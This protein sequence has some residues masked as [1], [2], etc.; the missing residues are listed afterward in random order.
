MKTYKLDNW[1]KALTN[2]GLL[3]YAETMEVMLFHHSHDSYRVPTLN[4]KFLCFDIITTIDQIDGLILD[5]GNLSPLIDEFMSSYKKDSVIQ[6]LYGKEIDKL[7]ETKDEH[8]VYR[9]QFKDIC[10]D[11]NSEKARASLRKTV[12]FLIDDLSNGDKYYKNILSQLKYYVVEDLSQDVQEQMYP[13]IQS[14]LSELMNRGYTLE[15]LY[16]TVI[17]SFFNEYEIKDIDAAFNSFI[18][19][20]S[21]DEK[22]YAVYFPVDNS[23]KDDLSDCFGLSIAEN[24]FEMFNNQ[25]RYVGKISIEAMDPQSAREEVSSIIDLF[26]SIIEYDKHSGKS[27]SIK[28]TDIVDIESK[29]CFYY[30][31]SFPP[32]LRGNRNKENTFSKDICPHHVKNLFNAISLHANAIKSNDIS[33]Q[34]LNLWTAIEVLVPTERKGLYSRIIQITNVLTTVLSITHFR[35]LLLQ[36]SDDIS[37]VCPQYDTYVSEIEG[38]SIEKIITLLTDISYNDKKQSLHC[39]VSQYPIIEYRIN[40][41]EKMLSSPKAMGDSYSE[42][43]ERLKQQIMRIY[44]TRNMIVHDGTDTIY[45]NLILQNL[46]YYV[47]TLIGSFYVLERQGYNNLNSIIKQMSEIEKKFYLIFSKSNFEKQDLKYICDAGTLYL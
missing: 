42:H 2:K 37:K 27:F 23:I 5:P 40:K 38:S 33:S 7:F 16:T 3:F 10:K 29:N 30:K 31:N 12:R 20:F 15:F 9:N 24:V 1:D 6:K 43:S 4:F 17:D 14:F 25:F 45:I 19:T 18:D 11:R 47:D 34:F 8:G 32:I 36:L 28:S 44:R 46:H 21:F 13:L 41:Y 22:K 39:D 26:C 35:T